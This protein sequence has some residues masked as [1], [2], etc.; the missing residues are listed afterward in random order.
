VL[1]PVRVEALV[2]RLAD[3]ERDAAVRGLALLADA[4]ERQMAEYARTTGRGRGEQASGQ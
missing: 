1:D 4:A 3:Q 2:A